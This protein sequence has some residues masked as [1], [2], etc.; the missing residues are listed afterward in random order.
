[1]PAARDQR[2]DAGQLAL[3][4]RRASGI[5]RQAAAV[6]G[7]REPEAEE[8]VGRGSSGP[9]GAEGYLLGKVLKPAVRRRA[10]DHVQRVHGLSQCR[11]CGLIGMDVSSCRYR[12]R[13]GD[14]GPLR[15]RLRALERFTF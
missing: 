14:D 15:E 12:S 4:L 9:G 11:A 3:A 7:R 5:G 6:A 1:M 10:V 8:A 2:E 13:R